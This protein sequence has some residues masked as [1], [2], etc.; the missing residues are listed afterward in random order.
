MP[1][2]V[3]AAGAKKWKEG[4]MAKVDVSFNFGANVK[5]RKPK[6]AKKGRRGGKGGAWAAY[7]SGKRR[8]R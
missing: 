5:R 7:V 2:P 6:G 3:W 8:G 4:V 1:Q